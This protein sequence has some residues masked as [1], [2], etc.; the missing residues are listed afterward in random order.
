[1][2][3]DRTRLPHRH[4]PRLPAHRAP[5]RAQAAP[6]RPSGPARSTRP[7]SRRPRPSCARRRA[8]ASPRSASAA[9]DSSI[10][11]SFSY[12]DQ[13]LDAAVAVGAVPERFA[14]LRDGGRHASTS[15]GYFTVARGEG[16]DAPA[17][18]DEV[19]RLELP[20]PR[21]RDRPRDGVPLL[22]AT[23]SSREV[24]EAKAAGLHRPV[25]SSSARSRSCCWRRPRDGAPDGLPPARPPRR[26]AAG[27]RRAARRAA[28][29][30]APS[31]CSS[32]SR[33]SSARASTM[34]RAEV[35]RRR[36]RRAYAALG[37][38]ER[39]PG[40][41]RRRA[42]T[43]ALGDALPGARRGAGRGHRRR[44]RARRRARRATSTGLDGKTLVGGV[45]R[46][47]QH[48]ARRPR[49]A[50][51]SELEAL[52]RA[53]RRRSRSSTSTSLLHVPH[54]VDDET[55]A[56]RAPRDAGSP[57]PTRRSRRSPRSRGASPRGAT[58]IEGELD[59][60]SAALA[61]RRRRARRA[62]RPRCAHAP[63]ALADARLRPRRR[64]TSA[65]AA[66]E[67]RS[68]CPVLPTTTIGSFPQTGEIRRARARATA[69]ASSRRSEYEELLRDEIARVIDLQ[70][71]LGLDVLVH[72]EPERNDMVQYFAENLDGFAVTQQ[73]LGA[74]LRLALRRA[75]RSSGATC[76]ARRRSPSSG[77]RS[78]SRSPRSRSRAC[79]PAR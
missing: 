48:L 76:R 7:S 55:D 69:R 8:S 14:R 25:R 36:D 23:A 30:P 21:A 49:R 66:Q 56:R 45:D 62:R 20:L 47:P 68:T 19:V 70:E 74:V 78:R 75:R 64:T 53:R 5:P 24:A 2:N 65:S 26:P 29:R 1:M 27:L 77:R 50:R 11:E 13:V 57:S 22:A 44:P 9:T 63:R 46:R 38:A 17:R 18:D 15:R 52:A 67:R 12:Y 32:T 51:S 54:D 35:A 4:D 33:R 16:D 40:D 73:R 3:D 60:A 43:R 31:G 59:A 34:P 10:P 39:P 72:G 71:E 42:A 61:D 79:S 41:L 28:P 37:A 6:S 58:A